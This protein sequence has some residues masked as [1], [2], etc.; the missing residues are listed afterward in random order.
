M[1]GVGVGLGFAAAFA[2]SPAP[3][4]LVQL[5]EEPGVIVRGVHHQEVARPPPDV[6]GDHVKI[7][8]WNIDGLP[9]DSFSTDNGIITDSARRWPL[10]I[11]P[12]MQANKWVKKMSKSSNLVTFKLSDGDFARALA[13]AGA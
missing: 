10:M 13:G 2:H 7:R 9:K 12:Q 11:D 5:L 1:T 8:Q 4:V 6:L 3:S